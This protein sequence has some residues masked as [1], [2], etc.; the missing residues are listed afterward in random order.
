MKKFDLKHPITVDG[1]VIK[2][3]TLL[4]RP[5]AGDLERLDK[6]PGPVA[7]AVALIADLAEV[8]P[9]QVR[10]LDAADFMAIEVEVNSFLS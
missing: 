10:D 1:V 2:E 8:T 7:K 5:K 6:Y 3:L 9:D 4:R